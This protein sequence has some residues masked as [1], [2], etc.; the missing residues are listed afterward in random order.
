MGPGP[1]HQLVKSDLIKLQGRLGKETKRPPKGNLKVGSRDGGERGKVTGAASFEP[2]R[3][4]C[5]CGEEGY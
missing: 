3:W 4:L 2:Q 1:L 5:A